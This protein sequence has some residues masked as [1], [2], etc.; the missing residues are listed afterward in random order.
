[1]S[2]RANL[3][4]ESL[5]S[6]FSGLDATARRLSA[7]EV[8][9]YPVKHAFIAGW[10]LRAMVAGNVRELDALLDARFPRTP[11]RVALVDP[12]PFLTWPHVEQDGL[13]CLLPEEASV[14]H[15]DPVGAAREILLAALDL[16]EDC[17]AG[18]NEED[19]RDEFFSYWGRAATDGIQPVVSLLCPSEP[20]RLIRVWRGRDFNLAAD[21]DETLRRWF[22]NRHGAWGD[23]TTSIGLF[24]GLKR[25]LLPREYPRTGAD[26]RALLLA[27]AGLEA[28]LVER[29]FADIPD[30][31]ILVL[32]APTK[33]GPVLAGLSVTSP[34]REVIS[35]GS[36]RPGRL[37]GPLVV[38]RYLAKGPT[39]RSVIDRADA[40][41]VHSRGGDPSLSEL[42]G[43]TVAVLGCGSLG[44]PVAIMLAQ[45]GVGGVVLVD[46][47]TLSRT[48]TSRHP[49]GAVHVGAKKA[50]ALAE[51]IK[52]S[53]PEIRSV[54][55]LTTT[56]DDVLAS[57]PGVLAKCDLVVMTTGRWSSAG[58]LNE[59]HLNGGRSRPIVH[60]WLEPHACAAHAV[61]IAARGGC[62]QCGF[63]VV[64]ESILR[65]TQW[66]GDQGRREPG[67][68]AV[69]Q[70][71][72]PAA[73]ARGA[74][75]LAELAL[76][77]LRT[78]P[79]ESR[80][81]VSAIPRRVLERAGGSW[82]E[83]WLRVVEGRA[84]GGIETEQPWTVNPACS[85]CSV[86]MSA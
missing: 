57:S 12:P 44:A 51:H 81:R 29:A 7:A 61:V 36:F 84:E 37:P 79:A 49:L 28:G 3:A 80:V 15:V 64:G 75:L 16:L 54:T 4:I 31:A 42:L 35:A 40:E 22:V 24:V 32:G 62:L 11:V 71:Y 86:K 9:R 85:E 41:W 67:C 26:V 70:A 47:D 27:Q 83:E 68:G 77:C 10:R 13:L 38:A 66:P 50:E 52:R 18:R 39:S 82:T 78:S 17:V 65:V 74:A 43:S 73:V 33:N 46:P 45:A 55:A 48:N 56:S 72:G 8:G 1:M 69:Y 19:F 14:S 58:A 53:F 23:R 5:G 60:G 2:E 34:G 59:W 20:S 25:P 76:D 30:E 6:L 63:S 21:N